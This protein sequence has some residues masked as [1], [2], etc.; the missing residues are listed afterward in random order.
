MT[1]ED[2]RVISPSDLDPAFGWCGCHWIDWTLRKLCFLHEQL[3]Y[4]NEY[5]TCSEC[6]MKTLVSLWTRRLV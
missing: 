3:A 1:E 5:G 2:D 6:R 4:E